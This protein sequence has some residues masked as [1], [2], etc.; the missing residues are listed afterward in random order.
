MAS[1]VALPVDKNGAS[2]Q[3]PWVNEST[4]LDLQKASVIEEIWTYLTD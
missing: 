1:F 2:D 3:Q 4:G